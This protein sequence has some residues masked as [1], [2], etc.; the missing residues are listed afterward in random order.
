MMGRSLVQGASEPNQDIGLG[1][2][3]LAVVLI[4]ALVRLLSEWHTSKRKEKRMNV[5]QKYDTN[6]TTKTPRKFWQYLLETI[7]ATGAGVLAAPLATL[8]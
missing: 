3:W 1:A 8:S 5:V 4:L 7:W 6:S 2:A